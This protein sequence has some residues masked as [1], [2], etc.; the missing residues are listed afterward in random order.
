MVVVGHGI[1]VLDLYDTAISDIAEKS[2]N[3]PFMLAIP[4]YIGITYAQQDCW[5]HFDFD[6]G[7]PSSKVEGRHLDTRSAADPLPKLWICSKA[8]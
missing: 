5:L 7:R 1:A 2:P 4:S 3:N 8:F 6:A